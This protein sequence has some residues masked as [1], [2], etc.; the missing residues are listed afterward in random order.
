MVVVGLCA[1]LARVGSEAVEHRR[2]ERAL[3]ALRAA[4]PPIH[5][6]NLIFL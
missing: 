5:G 2:Q 3:A 1:P 6:R 4:G